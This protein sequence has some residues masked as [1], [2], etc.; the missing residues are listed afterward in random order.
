LSTITTDSPPPL[1][2]FQQ[3]APFFKDTRGLL[4][5]CPL[6]PLIYVIMVESLNRTLE[7]ERISGEIPGLFIAR[8]VKRINHSQF[9]DDALLVGGASRII[10]KNFKLVLE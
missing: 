2:V 10:S 3:I 5:G 8:G 7:W 1:S 6:S 4:Q 9:V